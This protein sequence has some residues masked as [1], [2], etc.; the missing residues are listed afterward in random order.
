M[1]PAADEKLP[2]VHDAHEL[3]LAAEYV[4]AV[5]DLQELEPSNENSPAVQVVHALSLVAPAADENLPAV[6][7]V[8]ELAAAAEYLPAGKMVYVLSKTCNFTCNLYTNKKIEGMG[9]D[10]RDAGS[11]VPGT[12]IGAEGGRVQASLS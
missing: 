1:A 11:N 5:H 3:A 2:A 10:I 6:H 12:E 4:P 9:K 7:D 8:Q